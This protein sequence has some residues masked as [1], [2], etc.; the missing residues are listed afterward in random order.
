M[1]MITLA[2]IS[3]LLIGYVLILEDK[4]IVFQEYKKF[5]NVLDFHS[6]SHI[7]R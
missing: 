6:L 5:Q 4:I 1:M 2:T 3:S 7:L